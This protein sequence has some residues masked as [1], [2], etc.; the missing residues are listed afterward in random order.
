MRRVKLEQVSGDFLLRPTGKS[1]PF[2]TGDAIHFRSLL[3]AEHDPAANSFLFRRRALGVQ[4][5][6]SLFSYL[7]GEGFQLDLDAGASAALNK[8]QGGREVLERSR[9]EGLAVKQA[10]TKTVKIGRFRR[11]LKPFQIPATAHMI[12]VSHPANFS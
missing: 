9:R 8:I 7:Q 12:R 2:T 4:G 5:I 6:R 3:A 10:R 1:D 11:R